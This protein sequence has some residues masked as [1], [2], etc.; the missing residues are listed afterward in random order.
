MSRSLNVF[1][2]I[3]ATALATLG[4]VCAQSACAQY[5]QSQGNPGQYG[6]GGQQGGYAAYGPTAEM[7]MNPEPNN[8]F[9]GS[10]TTTM[11][12]QDGSGQ[13]VSFSEFLPNGNTRA[14]SI[15]QGGSMNNIRMQVWGKYTVKQLGPHRYQLTISVRGHAPRQMCMHGGS[16]QNMDLP[17]NATETDDMH[18]PDSYHSVTTLN[19]VTTEAELHRSPVPP[20][21]MSLVG[22]LVTFSAPP[23][24]A[25]GGGGG[26]GAPIMPT[27]HPYVTP[28]GGSYH[29]PGQGGTCDDAQQNRICSVNSGHMYTDSRG[30]RMCA[31]PN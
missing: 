19:G 8:P 31:G 25:Q 21:L 29:V 20:Q 14:T 3:T 18:G 22:P 24:A 30:C 16:C 11:P 2:F 9:I 23:Q 1:Q 5:G 28:G 6:N 26:G 10:W 13:I 7:N 4:L 27:M 12:M 15:F 17:T